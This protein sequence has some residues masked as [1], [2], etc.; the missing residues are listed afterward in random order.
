M[1]WV[2][3]LFDGAMYQGHANLVLLNNTSATLL[4]DI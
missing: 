2:A 1:R 4:Q 3:E